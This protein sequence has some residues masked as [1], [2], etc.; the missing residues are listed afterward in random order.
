M[1][2]WKHT[3]R[4]ELNIWRLQPGWAREISLKEDECVGF[5][6]VHVVHFPPD[7]D[8]LYHAPLQAPNW[9]PAD[10]DASLQQARL[11]ADGPDARAALAAAPAGGA[12]TLALDLDARLRLLGAALLLDERVAAAVL[13]EAVSPWRPRR[14]WSDFAQADLLVH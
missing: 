12:R 8:D 7:S 3:P 1:G 13:T 10:W 4:A 2:K 9:L 5:V 6:P 11:S 14:L